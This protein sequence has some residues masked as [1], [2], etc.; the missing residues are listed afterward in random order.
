M[1]RLAVPM[2]C[3]PVVTV[4]DGLLTDNSTLLQEDGYGYNESGAVDELMLSALREERK[5]LRSEQRVDAQ[6]EADDRAPVQ[7]MLRLHAGVRVCVWLL[8][9]SVFRSAATQR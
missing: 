9:R 8:F 2:S 6:D 7:V 1:R 5:A 3:W 4:V